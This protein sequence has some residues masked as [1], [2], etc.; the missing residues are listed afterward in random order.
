MNTVIAYRAYDTTDAYHVKNLLESAEI[1]CMIKNE[2][3]NT[4]INFG[5]MQKDF[6]V[7]VMVYEKD[8]Q[9][10]RSI[11][12]DFESEKEVPK[13]Q[14]CGSK[15]LNAKTD[16]NKILQYITMFF[17]FLIMVPIFKFNLYYVCQNCG[18]RQD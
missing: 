7:F 15:D 13:C 3:I 12:D 4:V 11:I 8:L 18:R 9:N 14:Y 17:S 5:G 6:E 1:N 2:N 10:A 16:G